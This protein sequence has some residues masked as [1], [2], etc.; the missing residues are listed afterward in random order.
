MASLPDGMEI[1]ESGI[2]GAGLGVF[3]TQMFTTG[4]TFGPY[5]G[6]KVRADIP[7]DDIDTSYMWEVMSSYLLL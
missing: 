3:A 7:K 6:E 4:T 1:K 5:M 2:D